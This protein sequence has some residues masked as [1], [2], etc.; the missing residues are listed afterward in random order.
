MKLFEPP[1]SINSR[2]D[3]C[4]W[5]MWCQRRS[6]YWKPSRKPNQSTPGTFSKY[7]M[8]SPW[9][10]F[11]LQD[12]TALGSLL[13]QN[14]ANWCKCFGVSLCWPE[15][16]FF[17]WS[18]YYTDMWLMVNSRKNSTN[19]HILRSYILSQF[20]Y[21]Q[22]W[23]TVWLII[24]LPLINDCP[25]EMPI[26]DFPSHVSLPEGKRPR[27]WPFVNPSRSCCKP[28][29]RFTSA[30]AGLFIGLIMVKFVDAV[31]AETMFCSPKKG[32]LETAST[33][34]PAGLYNIA[35]A[36]TRN[37]LPSKEPSFMALLVKPL[38]EPSNFGTKLWPTIWVSNIGEN[39]ETAPAAAK[40]SRRAWPQVEL[41]LAP[42]A[43]ALSNWYLVKSLL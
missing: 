16:C 12:P 11:R 9:A 22:K 32:F 41:K 13:M 15:P 21:P 38:V 17:V 27:S 35:M 23:F 7:S 1:I 29:S 14:Y 39:L 33:C 28:S 40:V 18:I 37:W 24:K 34:F 5:R 31:S 2:S 42:S 30:T 4:N 43:A 8:R 19:D 26:G 36:Q 25:N 3:T 10:S 6:A 20:A